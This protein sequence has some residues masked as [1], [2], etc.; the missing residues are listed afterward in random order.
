MFTDAQMETYDNLRNGNYPG[1]EAIPKDADWQ[2]PRVAF[3]QDF[4][5]LADNPEFTDAPLLFVGYQDEDLRGCECERSH[6]TY[7]PIRGDGLL[8]PTLTSNTFGEVETTAGIDP[9]MLMLG[10][11]D[12]ENLPEP[13][14]PTW[15]AAREVT[16]D[17]WPIGESAQPTVTDMADYERLLDGE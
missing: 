7:S 9:F 10:M 12:P 14:F 6:V 15:D 16:P 13:I 2:P 11:I 1:S 8:G 5:A 4:P 3:P 17:E